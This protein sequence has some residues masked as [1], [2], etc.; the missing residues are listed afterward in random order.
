M[1]DVWHANAGGTYSDVA[2]N[3]SVGQKYLRGLQVTGTS[4]LARFTTIYPGWYQGRAVHIHFKVRLFT[5]ATETYEFNSQLFFD[6]ATTNAVYATGAYAARGAPS[7]S[8][9]SDGI[10]GA[11]GSRLVVPLSSNGSGGLLGAYTVGL[12][13]LPSGTGSGTTPTNDVDA[14][15][16][17]ARFR[18]TKTGRRILRVKLDVD[19]RLTANVRLS[20]SDRTIA[21]RRRTGIAKGTRTIDLP[22]PRRTKGGKARLTVAMK[23]AAGT[24]KVRRR[25]VT[26]PKRTV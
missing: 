19:E 25:T 20:R 17:S 24:L 3:G 7:T 1:V 2:Q 10:Y 13:G 14:S 12:S 11:D 23:D 21:R 22:V 9:A 8:N 15:I 5:G 6:P 4:G 16:L 26:V 18:R